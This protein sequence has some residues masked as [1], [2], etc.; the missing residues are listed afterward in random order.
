MKRR[1]R[2]GTKENARRRH[3]LPSPCLLSFKDFVGFPPGIHLSLFLSKWNPKINVRHQV[4]NNQYMDENIMWDLQQKE[5]MPSTL[6]S[7]WGVRW[8]V[9]SERWLVYQDP[10]KKKNMPVERLKNKEM[11]ALQNWENGWRLLRREGEA[12]A[13]CTQRA[14]VCHLEEEIRQG[15]TWNHF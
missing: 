11:P 15:T 1:K 5:M 14:I 10:K 2:R 12:L 4:I 9:T 7:Y 6:H 8:L 13:H 3:G